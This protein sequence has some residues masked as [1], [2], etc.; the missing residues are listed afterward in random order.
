MEPTL[1]HFVILG[2]VTLVF[3]SSRNRK[4]QLGCV[5]LCGSRLPP[6][7]GITAMQ[8]LIKKMYSLVGTT[9]WYSLAQFPS[10]AAQRRQFPSDVN[11]S[12]FELA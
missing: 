7:D 5:V 10:D 4:G 12:G 2:V 11:S 1:S 6:L 9:L 8:L 3:L